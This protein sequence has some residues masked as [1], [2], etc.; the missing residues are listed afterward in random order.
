MLQYQSPISLLY[1]HIYVD[2]FFGT[3]DA[4]VE[5]DKYGFA[6]V[7]NH[8]DRIAQTALAWAN[9]TRRFTT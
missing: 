7:M 6:S 4:Y 1:I 2:T 5:Y 9:T 8:Q 3:N